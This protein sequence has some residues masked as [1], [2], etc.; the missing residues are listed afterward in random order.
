MDKQR[1]QAVI[2]PKEMG[3]ERIEELKSKNLLDPDRRIRQEGDQL[4][5]PVIKKGNSIDTSPE[6]RPKRSTPFQKIKKG[7]ELSKEKKKILPRR[8]EK[9]GD[10]LLIKLPEKLNPHKDEIAKVYANVLNTKTVLLQGNI[11]G[12]KR[13]PEVEKIYGESTETV[14]IENGV[15]FK[16]DTQQLMFSSGNIDERIRMSKSVKKGET[17]IDMFAGIGYFTLPMGVHG[18]PRKIYAL[19]INP[20][21]FS[22]L[23]ENIALNGI[24]GTVEPRLGDNRD[25]SF[26]GADRII[27]GYLH[28]T[29]KY[30]PKALGFLNGSG[31]IHYH[32]ICKD[33]GYPGE[34]KK[35]LEKSINIGFQIIEMHNIK[36]YAPHMFHVVADVEILK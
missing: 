21:A 11:L 34:V 22:Y 16:L 8:W 15:K 10:V 32:T 31:I 26:Q 17:V 4:I 5:I 1:K 13:E 30:I 28:E 14:H 18:D 29:Y 25:F 36:S 20:T 24:E 27:M 19:E 9:I 6:L 33:S 12:K 7:I 2:V 35:E 23:K 3:Q